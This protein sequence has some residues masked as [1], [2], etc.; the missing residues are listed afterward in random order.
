VPPIRM[1]SRLTP[2]NKEER[3]V[4]LAA[5]VIGWREPSFNSRNQFADLP[6]MK[7]IHNFQTNNPRARSKPVLQIRLPRTTTTSTRMP[8]YH[9]KAMTARQVRSIQQSHW[10][11]KKNTMFWIRRKRL[12]KREMWFEFK[13]KLTN[14]NQLQN[15]WRELK[16][17]Q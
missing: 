17:A 11:P 4:L 9:P 10:Q 15:R 8:Y 12:A 14:L 2:A 16:R 3:E 7:I 1:T 5:V 13:P 6:L